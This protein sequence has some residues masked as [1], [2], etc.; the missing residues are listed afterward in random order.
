MV[1]LLDNDKIQIMTK[2]AIYEEKEGKE[3]IRLSKYYRTDYIRYHLL[4]TIISV[5]T[6]YLLILAM[7]T[8][9]HLEYLIKMAVVLNYKG[10]FSKILGGYIAILVIYG[11]A[12]YIGYSIRFTASRKKLK[13]YY[14]NLKRLRRIYK[15]KGE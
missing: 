15:E 11:F 2:L 9:Y 6:G 13:K 7:I 4:K 14:N 5:T 8:I 12:T 10:L 3:D 1:I